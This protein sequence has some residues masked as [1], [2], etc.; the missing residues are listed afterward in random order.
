[1]IVFLIRKAEGYNID[2]LKSDFK[3]D[4]KINWIFNKNSSFLSCLS[5]LKSTINHSLIEIILV[6]MFFF[7]VLLSNSWLDPSAYCL[8]SLRFLDFAFGL[9]KPEIVILLDGEFIEPEK[10]LLEL[11]S[12]CFKFMPPFGEITE[13]RVVLL[14]LAVLR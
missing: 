12:F 4:K 9:L 13:F 5:C 7:N 6:E 1:M 3:N 8:R 10:V 2:Q 14:G 11:A